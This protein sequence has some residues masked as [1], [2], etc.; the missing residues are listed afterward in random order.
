MGR[1]PMDHDA[2]DRIAAAAERDPAGLTAQSGF[3]E[4][5][6]AA[7]DRNESDSGR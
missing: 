2:A 7:A 4:R 6:G 5:A 1:T 3:S